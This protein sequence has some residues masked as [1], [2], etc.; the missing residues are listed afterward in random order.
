MSAAGTAC[1]GFARRLLGWPPR[2]GLDEG[3][4]RTIAAF[5]QGMGLPVPAAA[6]ARLAGAA[7]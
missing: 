3:L 4:A 6:A 7:G 2:I 1:A 5:A